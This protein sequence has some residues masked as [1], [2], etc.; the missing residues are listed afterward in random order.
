MNVARSAISSIASIHGQPAGQ[1]W[2][3]RRFLKASFNKRPAL[4]RY[5]TTWDPDTVLKYIEDM[6]DN[7][8]LTLMLLSQKLMMLLLLQ[9][10][11]R[12][13]TIEAFNVMEMDVTRT[14]ATFK[15]SKLLKTSKTG[16]H[17]TH[18]T[19]KSFPHNKNLCVHKTLTH[20]LKRTLDIRGKIH[21]LLLTTTLPTKPATRDTLRRW[22]K[23]IMAEAGIDTN[24]YL[25]HSTRS[26][27]TS[28]A[29]KFMSIDKII[30]HVGW[31]TESTFAKYYDKEISNL[32]FS[33]I[34]AS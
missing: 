3:V 25:P 33:T 18:I 26:A 1:H 29:K 8:K 28:K 24:K 30:E 23:T 15:F 21:Q 20:Y 16:H 32:E 5:T 27:A 22:T 17:L 6:G 34:I 13:Q 9:S 4:P 14:E 11:A 2:L 10:G 19:F 31:R 12:M 7:K